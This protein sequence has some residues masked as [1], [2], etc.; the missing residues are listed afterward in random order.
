MRHPLMKWSLA[1][2]ALF[3]CSSTSQAQTTG[4]RKPG[5]AQVSKARTSA[6]VPDFSG[7]WEPHMPESAKKYSGYSF[8]GEIPPMTPWGK[9]QYEATKPSWGPRAVLDSTDPVNPTTGT[10]HEVGCFPPG[11][12][13]IYVHHFPMEILQVPGHVVQIFEFGH[14]VREIYTNGAHEHEKDL[15]PSWMGDS[16][17]WWEGDTL[18]IDSV[19]F[20]DKTWLDRAGL[21]HSDQ[22]H[23]V[24]HI[25]RPNHGTLEID[26]MVDDPKAYTTTFGGKEI[27]ELRPEWKIE[28][29]ICE[30]N[31]NFNE[32]KK[33][34]KE[35]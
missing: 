33:E 6:R 11:V 7:V 20:N 22:L 28:E 13:R 9:A 16:I 23:V 31:V 12:P 10:G 5:T 4:N 34:G 27:Y 2:A 32:L 8:I 17:G 1:L 30:D 24:E 18:V 14:F 15:N 29:M 21:P 25:R 3:A 19:G 26:I 35:Q